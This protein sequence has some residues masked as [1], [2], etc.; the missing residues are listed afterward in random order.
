MESKEVKLKEV[1]SREVV[2]RGQRRS[3][4]DWGDFGQTIQNVKDRRNK[5]MR[6]ILQHGSYS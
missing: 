2:A 5:F 4:W 6:F 3:G 1:D